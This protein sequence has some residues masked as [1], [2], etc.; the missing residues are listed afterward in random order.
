[1]E[2]MWCRNKTLSISM[3]MMIQVMWFVCLL[4]ELRGSE[5]GLSSA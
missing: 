5:A 1:M 3:L 2:E 4:S